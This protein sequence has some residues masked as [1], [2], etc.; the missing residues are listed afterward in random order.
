MLLRLHRSETRSGADRI[1]ERAPAQNGTYA[2][3]AGVVDK[4]VCRHARCASPA[5]VGVTDRVSD[6]RLSTVEGS[7]IE[8]PVRSVAGFVWVIA[9]LNALLWLRGIAS[10]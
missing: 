4:S 2:H 7:L 1:R 9:A 3:N 6:R 10:S 5:E 8:V